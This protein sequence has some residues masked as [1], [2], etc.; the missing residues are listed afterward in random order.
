ME[1]KASPLDAKNPTRPA[2]CCRVRSW[3]SLNEDRARL[4][5]E[6]HQRPIAATSALAASGDTLLDKSAAEIGV[7]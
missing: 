6:R 2:L 7:D 1:S 5:A 3:R 4:R